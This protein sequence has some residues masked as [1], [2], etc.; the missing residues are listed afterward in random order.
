MVFRVMVLLVLY[1][2]ECTRNAVKARK[3]LPPEH[4]ATPSRAAHEIREEAGEQEAELPAEPAAG[5][6]G[7]VEGPEVRRL[8]K[9]VSKTP[10]E[11]TTHHLKFSTN[12]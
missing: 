11:R 1:R 2:V 9:S 5:A 10:S 7:D 12:V 4:A 8:A 3:T 6:Y